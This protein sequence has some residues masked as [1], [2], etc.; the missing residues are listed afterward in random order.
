MKNEIIEKYNVNVEEQLIT[1]SVASA[2]PCERYDEEKKYG[3]DEIL[4]IDETAIDNHR[5]DA[6][7]SVLFGH[8]ANRIL[9][10][11]KGTQVINE[12]LYA[13]VAFR[14]NDEFSTSIF[15]DIID[16]TVKNVSIG[17]I[18]NHYTE[19]REGNRVVRYIDSWM[20]FEISIV[21][22]PADENVGIRSLNINQKKEDKNMAEE[23]VKQEEVKAKTVEELQA[24]NEKLKQEL[25]ALKAKEE[26][27]VKPEEE[28]TEEKP[29]E[30]EA[31]VVVEEE[32]VDETTIDESA[33]EE[34]IKKLAKDFNVSN[35]DM[36]EVIKNKTSVREF[37]KNIRDGVF[38]IINN[39]KEKN[40]S[41]EKMELR[42]MF[43]NAGKDN[44]GGKYLL[45]TFSGFGGASGEGGASLIGTETFPLVASLQKIMGVKGFKTINGLRNNVSIP[46]QTTRVTVGQAADLRSAVN[47]SNPVF[48]PVTLSPKKISGITVIGRDLLTQCND[49]IVSFIIDHIT[50]EIAYKVEDYM[51]SKVAGATNSVEYTALSAVDWADVLEFES[52]LAGY[53]LANPSFVMSAS[54]R[55]ALKGIEKATGTAQYLCDGANQINGYQANVSGVVSNDNIY[56][57]DWSKLLLGVFGDGLSILVDPYTYSSEG[58]IKIVGDIQIDACLENDGA[59]VVGSVVE[60]TSSEEPS[61]EA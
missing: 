3:Y 22:V 36:E 35:K 46:V 24:E 50:Q 26:E 10:V 7:A 28:V 53:N 48:T 55:A 40:M 8:D 27:E 59:F 41:K 1:F 13:T 47:A 52:K 38:N 51:L 42:E 2:T 15:K 61:G 44:Q 9:G 56:F 17:Y 30:G 34:E 54:A 32:V 19:K 58:N 33:D 4:L 6:G 57:G 5:L 12:K 25:E 18:V 16:G 11:V 21:G 23:E 39:K 31:E 49:D 14:K 37:K 29:K 45:R 60:E 43:L 20:P